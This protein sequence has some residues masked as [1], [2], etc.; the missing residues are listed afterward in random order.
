MFCILLWDGHSGAATRGDR[1]MAQEKK[2]IVVTGAGDSRYSTPRRVPWERHKVIR[3]MD[4][5]EE[6]ALGQSLH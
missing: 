3:R 5:S 6:K 1:G 2:L 4:R